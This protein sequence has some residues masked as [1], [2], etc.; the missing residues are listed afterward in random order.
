MTELVIIRGLPGSGKSTL[1]KNDFPGYLHY[2]PD[3]FFLDCN[4]VYKFD[5]QLWSN[6]CDWTMLMVDF[7]LARGDNTVVSDVF[8]K[9]E[10]IEPYIKL[11]N[12]HG[13]TYKVIVCKEEFNNIH[14]VPYFVLNKMKSDFEIH[15][16]QL[17]F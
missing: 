12:F 6:A 17:E 16:K 8:A 2:E 10:H 7:A 15:P 1:A 9:L 4:G 5:M 3:H 14:N 11:A 13:V